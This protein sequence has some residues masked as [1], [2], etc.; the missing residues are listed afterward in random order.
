MLVAYQFHQHIARFRISSQRLIES[1]LVPVNRLYIIQRRGHGE[2][3]MAGDE[4]AMTDIDDLELLPPESYAAL[5]QRMTSASV[6]AAALVKLQRAF[7]D[8]RGAQPSVAT[9]PRSPV[10]PIKM[11]RPSRRESRVQGDSRKTSENPFG[12]RRGSQKWG[13]RKRRIVKFFRDPRATSF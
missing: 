13:K 10:P 3:L 1:A 2:M 9:T 6:G 7:A 12:P 8:I 4:F 5:E 11:G